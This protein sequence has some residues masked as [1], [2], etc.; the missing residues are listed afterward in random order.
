MKRRFLLALAIAAFAV[1][2]PGAPIRPAD[3]QQTITFRIAT[4][5]PQGSTWMRVF[6]AWN[7]SLKQATHNR[8]QMRFY[9]GG[10]AGDERDY[11]RKMRAGQLDGAAITSTGLGLV[12]RPVLVLQVPGLFHDYAQI[13]RVRNQL[14]GDLESKFGQAGYKL[15]GWG[16]VGKL[17]IFSNAPI[18]KPSDLRS[19]RPWAWRDDVIFNEF[20]HVV[21]ANGVPL[22]VPEVYPA[23]QTRM[24]DTVPSSALAAVSL[25]WYTRLKYVTKQSNAILIGA[26]IV[27]KDKFDALPPDLQHAFMQ[28]SAQAHQVLAQA[29]RRGDQQAYDTILHRGIQAVDLSAHQ[30]EW[31]HTAQQVRERLAGRLYSRALLQRVEQAARGH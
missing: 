16:D 18:R 28:T 19:V 17:R 7:A 13:D 30:A 3:A 9:P 2:I 26:T 22:G 6:N 11:I 4:L 25:Q 1:V 15:L 8:L 12:V 24:V 14:A 10:V 21:G 20:L 27:K 29:I 31:D 5:A 23:L